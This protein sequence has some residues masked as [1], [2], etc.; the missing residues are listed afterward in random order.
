MSEEST[1]T[2]ELFEQGMQTIEQNQQ[3][4]TQ[5]AMIPVR[6]TVDIQRSVGQMMMNGLELSDSIGRMTRDMTRSGIQSYMNLVENAISEVGS[7]GSQSGGRG[8]RQQMGGSQQ[9]T[10]GTRQQSP[11]GQQATQPGPQQT[12]PGLQQSQPPQQQSRPPQQQSQPPQQQSQP[13]QQ[14]SQPPQQQSQPPQQQ[15]QPPQQQSQPPQQRP[16]GAVGGFQSQY[17]QPSA[18]QGRGSEPGRQI[19][20]VQGGG[21]GPQTRLGTGRSVPEESSAQQ[22]PG[23]QGVS[24][25]TQRGNYEQQYGTQQQQPEREHQQDPSVEPTR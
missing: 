2:D 9:Q 10:R 23:V 6:Q 12:Q 25:G 21:Y 7:Q 5:S 15:S 3:S 8:G 18:V 16:Q 14:Q 11:P 17:G 20:P 19:Q 13:P 1:P 22:T 24:E 4:L